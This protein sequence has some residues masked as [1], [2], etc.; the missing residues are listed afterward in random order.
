MLSSKTM[1]FT[2]L[3]TTLA[4]IWVL[5]FSACEQVIEI[6]LPE[7]TPQLVVN[8]TFTPDSVFIAEV[9][10]S[11][12]LQDTAQYITF[13]SGATVLVYEDGVFFD[14]LIYGRN[15]FDYWYTSLR[16]P[17]SGRLYTIKVSHPGFEAVEG[18]DIAPMALPMNSVTFKDTVQ[19]IDEYTNYAEVTF[20]FNDPSTEDFYMAAVA[21]VDSYE[22]SPGQWRYMYY[23]VGSESDDPTM[24]ID[25][26]TRQ[27]TFSDAT[28]NGGSKTVRIRTNRTELDYGVP[29]VL[30]GRV[31][32]NYFQYTK[33]VSAY[34]ETAFNPFAEPVVIHSNMSPEM[35]IFA[36]YGVTRMR[37]P[38]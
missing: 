32:K 3:Y 16:K 28:F 37:V 17:Q 31:S 13:L 33:T 9:S 22:V 24:E 27:F 1:K 21:V 15:G 25:Y 14:S 30:L 4:L 29:Y 36:G 23:I 11:K 5:A 35:G 12:H 26:M 8:C 7:H 34:N 2:T 38:M 19:G 6:D 20:A 10:A 18:S